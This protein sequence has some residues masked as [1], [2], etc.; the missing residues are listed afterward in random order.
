MRGEFCVFRQFAALTLL[1]EVV[2]DLVDEYKAA[3][4]ENYLDYG[5]G[6]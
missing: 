6:S 5:N 3:E 2:A 1:R 4:H